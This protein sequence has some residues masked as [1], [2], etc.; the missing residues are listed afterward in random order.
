MTT[1]IPVSLVTLTYNRPEFIR[2]QLA[3]LTHIKYQPFEV[4]VIDNHSDHPLTDII[5]EYPF[6]QLHRMEEN[7]GITGRNRG[8]E[9][10]NGDIVITLDDDVIGITDQD[11]HHLISIFEDP[12]IG[13]VTFKVLDEV[14]GEIINWCHHRKVEEYSEQVFITEEIMEGGVAFRRS[15]VMG[16]GLYP[17]D[18]FISHEGPDLVLRIM[19]CGYNVIYSPKIIIQHSHATGGRTSWRRYYYD[20]RNLIWLVLRNYPFKRGIKLLTVGLVSMFVYSLRDG[21][22][23]YWFKGVVDGIKGTQRIL[24]QRNPVTK[25]TLDLLYEIDKYRPSIWYM[26]KKRLLKN[27]VRI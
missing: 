7:L 15:I 19:N 27:K 20:T 13:A 18:F 24:T 1:K 23:R 4:I 3:Q 21:F 9:L 8:I 16:A 25:R 17:E 2:K 11:I 12:V 14:T 10:A 6:A 22:L 26:L 5:K